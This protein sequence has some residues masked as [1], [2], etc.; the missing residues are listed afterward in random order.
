MIFVPY[1]F[2]VYATIYISY[3]LV[4]IVRIILNTKFKLSY[5]FSENPTISILIAARNEEASILTCLK[6]IEGLHYPTNKI[7]VWIGDDQS[8]DATNAIVSNY[9]QDKPYVKLVSIKPTLTQVK[10]KANVLAQLAKLATGEFLFITDADIQ[11]PSNWIKSLLSGFKDSVGIVSGSTVVDGSGIYAK[12][13]RIDWAYASGMIHVVS[14]MNIPVT[15][16]GNNMAIRKTCYEE[17]GGY[18]NLPFSVTEDLELFL[19][20]LKNGWG[21]RNLLNADSTARSSALPSVYEVLQQRKRWATG[22]FR[23][24]KIL[25]VFLIIQALYFPVLLLAFLSLPIL[26]VIPF[27]FT[28]FSLHAAFITV[29]SIKMNMPDIKK[30]I[31]LFEL[32]R[33]VFPMM[34]FVYNLLP[35]GVK[36]KGRTYKG[37]EIQPK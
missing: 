19:A 37:K 29:V 23:L 17:T 13:Q 20:V 4:L 18:E 24:P 30:Y 11:V 5:P 15:A 2:L 22:A 6:A 10:G 7:E 21:F 25:L 12:V 31:I 16:V 27:W 1:L 26:W 32:N 28:I 33:Y 14:D 36:W 9:I 8:T 3:Q 34:L 35:I